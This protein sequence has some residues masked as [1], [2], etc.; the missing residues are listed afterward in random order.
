MTGLRVR[1]VL[2]I[3]APLAL[4][5]LGLALVAGWPTGSS[6][7]PWVVGAGLALAALGTLAAVRLTRPLAHDL[8]RVRELSTGH[9]VQRHEPASH[10][11][12]AL[13][14]ALERL[15]DRAALLAAEQERARLAIEAAERL[16]TSFVAAMGHDLRNPMNSIVGFADLLEVDTTT[17][18]SQRQSITLIRRA[19]YDLLTQLDQILLWAKLEAGRLSLDVRGVDV[20]SLLR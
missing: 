18:S 11:G 6:S 20:A 2:A 8:V 3:A 1:C 14:R 19:A 4:S 13:S 5:A 7:V 10:E 16:R 15:L 9:D 17:A 12:A